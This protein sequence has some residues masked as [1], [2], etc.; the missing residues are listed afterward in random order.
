MHS[1]KYH[2]KRKVS[3]EENDDGVVWEDHKQTL[4]EIFFREQDFIQRFV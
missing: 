4:T 2:H 1:S 3:D